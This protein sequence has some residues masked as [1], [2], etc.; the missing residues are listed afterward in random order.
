MNWLRRRRTRR[1][2]SG[3]VLVWTALLL[4]VLI[5][6]AGFGVDVGSWYAR[7][8]QL[9][10][11][12]DAAALAGVAY[13]P[14]QT[15]ALIAAQNAAASNNVTD[16]LSGVSVTYT[17]IPPRQYQVVVTDNN[18]KRYFSQVLDN[19][20]LRETRKATAEYDL[21]VPLG[22]PENS[23]GT[24]NLDLGS[25][26]TANIWGA[27]NG[28]CTS[29]EDGD[30]LLSRYDAIR[31]GGG[32]ACPYPLSTYPAGL[33]SP[34]VYNSEY[35]AN[36]YYYDVE[37]PNIRPNALH[38]EAYDPA[39]QQ[40]GTCAASPDSPLI[41][42]ATSITTTFRVFHV[43]NP[44]DHTTDQLL[45]TNVFTTDDAASC[46]AWRDLWVIATSD[47]SGQYRIQ[48]T[49]SLG[50]TPEA[51]SYGSNEFSLRTDYGGTWARCN[52]IVGSPLYSSSC[53]PVHGE[54]NISVYAN[55]SGS[56]ATFYLAQVDAVYAGKEMDIQLYD[57]GEGASTISIL[58]PSGNPVGFT[59]STTDNGTGLPDD[60]TSKGFVPYS[61]GPTS[62]IDVS[63]SITPPS[64]F[65]SGSKFSDRHLLLKTTIPG[66]YT[67]PNGGW[68][69]IKYTTGGSGVTDRTTWS[70]SIIGNPVHLVS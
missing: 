28:Y 70:V 52:T 34:N 26:F 12:A 59:W 47:P 29:Q 2:E 61:S 35:D 25:G 22:S 4:V 24:G 17:P 54:N 38:I 10:R 41:S 32:Y 45:S 48:V 15:R 18:V 36:G 9:Q 6:M 21:P 16:G 55:Q 56:T 49:T 57:P 13:M 66:G 44:L 1:D 31:P 63:G 37:V 53:A 51:N 69:K 3:I 11:A 5:A 8:Q 65:A 58:D 30:R 14:D 23:L 7:S 62:S 40:S 50:S 67:A 39:Y 27:V 19:S 64:G 43:L 68:Y 60:A 20:A 33:T 42:G 46:A